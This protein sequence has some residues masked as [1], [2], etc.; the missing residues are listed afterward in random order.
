LEWK[1]Q[2]RDFRKHEKVYL[3][4]TIIFNVKYY[5]LFA[6]LLE[7]LMQKVW[8]LFRMRPNPMR[9]FSKFHAI[10]NSKGLWY[11]FHF[12][13]MTIWYS[14]V[15]EKPGFS[16]STLDAPHTPWILLAHPGFSL[17]TLDSPC[18]PWILLAHAGI[19]PHTLDSLIKMWSILPW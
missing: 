9:F 3:N 15:E 16:S 4:I 13:S 1:G 7:I 18:A 17:R 5:N 12:H 11:F 14:Y 19:S 2:I 10:K 8:M 6:W